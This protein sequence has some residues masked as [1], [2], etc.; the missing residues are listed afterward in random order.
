MY[1]NWHR[2]HVVG[3][4]GTLLLKGKTKLFACVYYSV[5]TCSVL[6]TYVYSLCCFC[7]G[8]GIFNDLIF[9]Q[10][11]FFF[12]NIDVHVHVYMTT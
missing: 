2:C 4:D 7:Q 10:A 12:Q 11:L 1:G 9:K 8:R 6:C 5:C 3:G